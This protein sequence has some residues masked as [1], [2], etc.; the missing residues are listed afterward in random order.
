MLDYIFFPHFIRQSINN[1]VFIV[2]APRSGTTYLFHTLA[3]DENSFTA[4]K[5]WEIIFAPSILQKYFFRGLLKFDHA[6]GRPLKK[7]ITFAENSLLGNFKHIHKIGLSLPEEDEAILLWSMSTCYLNFF[8]PD[9]THFY[10]YFSFDE[11]MS[12]RNKEQIMRYY[13]RYIQR[14]NFVFNRSGT[15]RFLSKNPAMMSKVKSLHQFFPD[16]TIVT[17]ARCPSKTIPS[18]IA[19]NNSIYSF[20]TSQQPG[21]S[22]NERTKN[23]L[24]NWYKMAHENISTFYSGQTINLSF[25]SLIKNDQS[26][27]NNLCNRL[28]IENNIFT[29]KQESERESH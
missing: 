15:K 4:F 3:S 16:A 25:S 27:I 22:M 8:F 6:I 20:F 28:S 9:T 23:I 1:P 11:K 5:L 21:Q 19:L 7:L 26:V 29:V 24:I 14:H 18:T 10:D 17:I 13:K 2:A 12:S